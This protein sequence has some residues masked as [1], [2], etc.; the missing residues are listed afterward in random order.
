MIGD[1]VGFTPYAG[2]AGAIRLAN[3]GV[4]GITSWE[5]PQ[6]AS[7]VNVTNF[8]SPTNANGVMVRQLIGGGIIEPS[9]T[10]EGIFDGDTTN[11]AAKFPLGTTVA[12][13]LLFSKSSLL[14]YHD[15]NAIVVEFNP[16]QRLGNDPAT[17]T[18]RLELIGDYALPNTSGTTTA[19]PTTAPP[20]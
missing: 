2:T 9:V 5:F 19:T 1:I 18:A 3:V 13:D 20:A 4:A 6:R 11:S 12:V 7:T 16:R 10:V 17:F 8:L 15:M 14:G